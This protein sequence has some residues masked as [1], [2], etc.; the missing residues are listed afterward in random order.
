MY[1]AQRELLDFVSGERK[2]EIKCLLNNDLMLSTH[3]IYIYANIYKKKKFLFLNVF[4]FKCYLQSGRVW[5]YD[6]RHFFFSL[7]LS[8]PNLIVS[9]L[10]IVIF[11]LLCGNIDSRFLFFFFSLLYCQRLYFIFYLT[12]QRWLSIKKHIFFF[13]FFMKH[14]IV[15]FFF[16]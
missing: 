10:S 5:L 16:L 11:R 7:L 9:R 15:F 14:F 8:S 12:T 6:C 2:R 1:H 4:S 3:T 13:F